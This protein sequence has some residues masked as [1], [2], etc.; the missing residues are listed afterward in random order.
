MHLVLTEKSK[1]ID[2]LNSEIYRLKKQEEIGKQKLTDKT[3]EIYELHENPL[4][5]EPVSL[6]KET[7]RAKTVEINEFDENPLILEPVSLNGKTERPDL[8]ENR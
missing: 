1:Q 7:E 2:S 8:V 3:D 4:I 6:N 5:L